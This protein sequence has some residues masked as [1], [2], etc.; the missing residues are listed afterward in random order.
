MMFELLL[1]SSEINILFIYLILFFLIGLIKQYRVTS[2]G[3][4]KI[5]PS[6]AIYSFTVEVCFRIDFL[7]P[8]KYLVQMLRYRHKDRV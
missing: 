2:N 5:K 4:N 6:S 3:R 8:L 1:P 7:R